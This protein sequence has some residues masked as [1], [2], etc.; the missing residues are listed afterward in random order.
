MT[1]NDAVESVSNLSFVDAV[2]TDI[3]GDE[4]RIDVT[5][6]VSEVFADMALSRVEMA[7]EQ[8]HK[9]ASRSE[10]SVVAE[11]VKRGPDYRRYVFTL[12]VPPADAPPA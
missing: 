6:T 3:A 12:W 5:A 4:T 1:V 8:Y 11:D 7:V 9:A 10:C 2:E